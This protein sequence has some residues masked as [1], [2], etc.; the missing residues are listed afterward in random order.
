MK[1]RFS[2]YF[3]LNLTCLVVALSS[4]SPP[5]QRAF[6]QVISDRQ[7]KFSSMCPM[8]QAQRR[9]LGQCLKLPGWARM[10]LSMTS[11]A[12]MDE[13]SLPLPK[14][15]VPRW[16]WESTWILSESG[17]SQENALKANVT[18]EYSFFSKICFLTGNRQCDR[19]HAV[20]LA[21]SQFEVTARN[22]STN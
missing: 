7:R 2:L 22:S 12:G 6:S 16:G 13:S 14:K 1:D 9:L 15:Q 18:D 3:Y 17:E 8:N 20:S 4:I 19:D 11:V 21:G 10:I 5:S